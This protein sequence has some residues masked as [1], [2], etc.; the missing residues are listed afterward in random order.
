[1]TITAEWMPG[2]VLRI[3]ALKPDP[4]LAPILSGVSLNLTEEQAAALGRVIA[5]GPE[6]KPPLLISEG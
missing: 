3:T 2:R 6:N 4:K 5:A 1:M